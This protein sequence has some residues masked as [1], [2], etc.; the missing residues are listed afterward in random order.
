M[1]Q[2]FEIWLKQ[3]ESL[4]YPDAIGLFKDSLK[5]FKND[6]DRPSYLLAYQGMMVQIRETIKH[7]K[8]PENFPLQEWKD[9][10]KK[11][12]DQNDW[13][14]ANYTAVVRLKLPLIL[15]IPDN[16]R[17]E[18]EHWRNLRNVCAHYKEYCFVKAHTLTLYAF[19][20]QYLLTIN[21]EGGMNTL[22]NEFEAYFDPLK[23][24][25][26]E[27]IEQ[28]LDKVISMVQPKEML[29][30]ITELRK[31]SEKAYRFDFYVILKELFDRTEGNIKDSVIEYLQQD[32]KRIQ[33][34]VNEYPETIVELVP[35]KEAY[36]FAKK[37][38]LMINNWGAVWANML[39]AGMIKDK[40]LEELQRNLMSYMEKHDKSLY[41]ISESQIDTLYRHGYFHMF[42]NEFLDSNKTQ[43]YE[44]YQNI[45]YSMSFY[46]S[47]FYNIPIDK[48]FVQA[49][50]DVFSE[51]K[52][53][54]ALGNFISDEYLKDE[55]IKN[56]FMAVLKDLGEELPKPLK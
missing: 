8:M 24:S 30:F 46:T 33:G 45:N 25:P 19:I 2:T 7:S 35:Q 12:K 16:V 3:N 43:K 29:S 23:T 5:C 11:L 34:F 39:V 48:G 15:V 55:D 42:V 31:L 37:N 52:Y 47:H 32:E 20:V 53:P 18:F 38:L 41:H 4:L 40:D 10:L 28:L 26:N 14:N 54:M 9:L 1:I 49:V 17:K 44:V 56:K 36:S 50:I 6:I 13:D 27:P 51:P 21:V 22:L